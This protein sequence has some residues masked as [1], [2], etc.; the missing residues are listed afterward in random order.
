MMQG[1]FPCRRLLELK[2]GNY[3]LRLGA[4]DRN[5]RVLGTASTTITI[6]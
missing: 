3:V 2:P 1:A 6:N 5:S 4:V